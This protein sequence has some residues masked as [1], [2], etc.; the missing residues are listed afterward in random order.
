A[1]VW[2]ADGG[3]LALVLAHDSGAVTIAELSSDDKLALTAGDDR[4]V[5]LWRLPDKIPDPIPESY[6]ARAAKIEQRM[7][8]HNAAITAAAFGRD[9]TLIA[10]G[11]RDESVKLWDPTTGQEIAWFEHADVVSSLAFAGDRLISG[12]RD[13]T[14]RQWK[15]P[16]TTGKHDLAS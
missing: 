10:T 9:D 12:S 4:V 7:V 13:G 2:S 6:S 8:G 3:K 1:R 11:S 14:A 5:R 16:E 15:L